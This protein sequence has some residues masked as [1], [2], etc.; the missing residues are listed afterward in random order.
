MCSFVS[1]TE[2]FPNRP[3]PLEQIIEVNYLMGVMSMCDGCH[4]T[5]CALKLFTVLFPS[6][7]CKESHVTVKLCEQ[8]RDYVYIYIYILNTFSMFV[9]V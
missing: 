3:F 7:L 6:A 2:H 4:D 8:Q 9:Y 5:V 1:F